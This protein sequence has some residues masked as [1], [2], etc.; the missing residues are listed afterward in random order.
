V[1]DQSRV[2][3]EPVHDVRFNVI[4]PHDDQEMTTGGRDIAPGE[5]V[6]AWCPKCGHSVV[7]QVL[8]L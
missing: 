8:R 3:G 5:R 1:T 7:I 2:T 4:C 6:T